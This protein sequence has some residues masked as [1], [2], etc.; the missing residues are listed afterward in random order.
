[1]R[2]PFER[3]APALPSGG[4]DSR[5]RRCCFADLAGDGGASLALLRIGMPHLRLLATRRLMRDPLLLWRILFYFSGIYFA[6]IILTVKVN[7]YSYHL[8]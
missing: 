2:T 7:C 4:V 8:T 5:G 6:E 1:V 3:A